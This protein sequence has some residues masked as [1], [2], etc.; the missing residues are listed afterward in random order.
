[1]LTTELRKIT[2][3]AKTTALQTEL[4][5][6]SRDYDVILMLIAE[7]ADVNAKS[8]TGN[9]ALMLAA[10][11]GQTTTVNAL[12]AVSGINVNIQ[13]S[14]NSTAL[15]LATNGGHTTIVNAL[16][17]VPNINVNLKVQDGNT[18]LHSAAAF[19]YTA[20]VEALL[21]V[22]GIRVNVISDAN[23]TALDRIN[24]RSASADKTAIIEA[25]R[26]K[27]AKTK[28]ELDSE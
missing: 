11:D 26:A 6:S 9:T 8:N 25:L 10:N 20:I 5:K 3:P 22:P 19:G 28:A 24:F 18:A 27:G 13:N 4:N 16:L 17:A 12:L 15:I 2:V 14:S 1:E 23:L 21:A 7:G